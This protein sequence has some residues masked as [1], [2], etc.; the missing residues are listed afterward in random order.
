MKFNQ[1]KQ[2][3][4]VEGKHETIT[5]INLAKISERISPRFNMKIQ[6]SNMSGYRANNGLYVEILPNENWQQDLGLFFELKPGF[7]SEDFITKHKSLNKLDPE[8]NKYYKEIPADP[9]L[10]NSLEQ[11]LKNFDYSK[12]IITLKELKL[13]IKNLVDSIN[14]KITELKNSV[15]WNKDDESEFNPHAKT[16][17]TTY[18]PLP[19]EKQISI[20]VPAF[21]SQINKIKEL[22]KSLENIKKSFKPND[23]FTGKVFI[24]FNKEN[25]NKDNFEI[26]LGKEI[27]E[28][29]EKYSK[30]HILTKTEKV[31]TSIDTIYQRD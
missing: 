29:E 20:T 1:L 24:G 4:I 15:E 28:L 10:L 14:K 17:K 26:K 21:T 19:K 13:E 7:K 22:Y 27:A 25:D 16:F 18:I 11:G 5:D 31:I 12:Y 2:I 23:I 30:E 3:L 8:T 9:E 6:I